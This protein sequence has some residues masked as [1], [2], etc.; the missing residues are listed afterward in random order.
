M[1]LQNP[2]EKIRPALDPMCGGARF[3]ARKTP[4]SS[5]GIAAAGHW[6]LSWKS[7]FLSV[8]TMKCEQSH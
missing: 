5:P 8:L 2:A 3:A 4:V 7:Y 6:H 1:Q